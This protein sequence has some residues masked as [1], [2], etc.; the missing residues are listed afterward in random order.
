MREVVDSTLGSL[1][2]RQCPAP[3][4]RDHPADA[5]T[6]TG[7]LLPA[8]DTARLTQP[9]QRLGASRVTHPGSRSKPGHPPDGLGLGLAI[10]EA[11]ANTHDATL[12]LRPRLNGGLIAH[13]R[14]PAAPATHASD[15]ALASAKS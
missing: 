5:V 8:E 11:I 14:F 9:F 4:G 6:N 1:R 3:A 2:T 12:E 10:V 13:V 15:H 7:P